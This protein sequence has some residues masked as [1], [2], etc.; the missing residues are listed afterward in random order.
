MN[1]DGT[2]KNL[3]QAHPGNTNAVSHGA[4]SARVIQAGAA[5]I[6]AELVHAYT[7]NPVERIAVEEVSKLRAAADLIDR[8][9]EEHGPVDKKGNPSYLID[10]RLRISRQLRDWMVPVSEAIDRQREEAPFDPASIGRSDYIRELQLIALGRNPSAGARERLVALTRLLDLDEQGAVGTSPPLGDI[11][12][13]IQRI[14]DALEA[15][16]LAR[17]KAQGGPP[18]TSTDLDCH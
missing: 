13:E 8:Y 16:T 12:K 6:E 17:W 15:R 7:F 9:L 4:H 1:K 11:D 3:I 10:R 2:R 5:V 18:G 14:M